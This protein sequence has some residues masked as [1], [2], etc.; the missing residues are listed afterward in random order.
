MAEKLTIP[1]VERVVKDVLEVYSDYVHYDGPAEN[2]S[3]STNSTSDTTDSKLAMKINAAGQP[4]WYEQI[5]KQGIAPTTA[6][7]YVVFRNVM[8]YGAKGKFRT[9]SNAFA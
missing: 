5:T 7:G 2:V 1:H 6:A 3:I 9:L 4:Y 8:D